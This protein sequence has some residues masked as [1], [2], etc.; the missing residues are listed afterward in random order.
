MAIHSGRN[1]LRADTAEPSLPLPAQHGAPIVRYLRLC[2]A[3]LFV[4][5]FA[6][7]AA[8]AASST[9]GN[10]HTRYWVKDGGTWSD[11][12]HWACSSGGPGGAVP[13]T[14]TDDCILDAKS[15]TLPGQVVVQDTSSTCRS[16][17]W[18]QVQ[19]NP[20]LQLD[21]GTSTLSLNGSLALSAAMNI[22]VPGQD[23]STAVLDFNGQQGS[24]NITLA[25][26]AFAELDLNE[27]VG[28]TDTST[29]TLNDDIDLSGAGGMGLQLYWGATLVTNGHSVTA[30]NV[31]VNDGATLTAS[32]STF[33]LVGD[34]GWGMSSQATATVAG[35]TIHQNTCGDFYGGGGTYGTVALHACSGTHALHDSSTF[36]ALILDAGAAATFD[37]TTNQHITTLTATGTTLAPI[38]ISASAAGQRATLTLGTPFAGD[39][40]AVQD[41]DCEGSTPC[42]AGSYSTDLGDNLHWLFRIA[43]CRDDVDGSGRPATVTDTVYISRALLG[44]PPVPVAFRGLDPALPADSVIAANV[45]ALGNA[46]DVDMDGRVDVTTD[47]VYIARH[48]LGLSPV[49]SQFRLLNPTIPADSVIAAN[50][51]ALCP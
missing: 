19:W 10:S 3:L 30:T 8:S 49:P 51:D 6:T 48:L 1:D 31:S 46:L 29:W 35:A 50:I 38:G 14:D 16:M 20:T 32:T 26:H 44:L 13:P 5:L 40:L 28:Q 21:P 24:Y 41:I 17:S 25:G 36:A 34:G 37:S 22:S 33:D 2:C 27:F 4:S 42:D 7:P 12:A 43:S 15:F 9:C 18:T 45:A 39:H 23:A 47:I 11:P